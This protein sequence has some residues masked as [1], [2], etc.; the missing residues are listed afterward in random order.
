[1]ASA[2]GTAPCG[3]D[4]DEHSLALI[5]I[6]DGL[7]NILWCYIIKLLIEYALCAG[8]LLGNA[9]LLCLILANHVLAV[10]I[11]HGFE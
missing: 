11:F 8:Q 2:A 4:V 3:P 5:L 9:L 7:K 1:M 10:F 6:E